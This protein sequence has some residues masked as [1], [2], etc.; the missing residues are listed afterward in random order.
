MELRAT[1]YE[2]LDET[3]IFYLPSGHIVSTFRPAAQYTVVE[4]KP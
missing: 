1:H 3:M 4:V 2:T